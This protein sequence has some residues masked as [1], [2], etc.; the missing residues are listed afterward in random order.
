MNFIQIAVFENSYVTFSYRRFSK[1]KVKMGNKCQA[2]CVALGDYHIALETGCLGHKTLPWPLS[3]T[4][5]LS[6][7]TNGPF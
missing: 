1:E 4:T 5:L 2:V 6:D 7:H 3:K